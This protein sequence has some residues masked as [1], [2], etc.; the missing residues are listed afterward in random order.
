M[1]L[2]CNHYKKLDSLNQ[3]QI[4]LLESKHVVQDSIILDQQKRVQVTKKAN[5]IST[6][7]LAGLILIIL[8]FK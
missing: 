2:C 6:L 1:D 5:R 8:I 4:E 3:V 7:G